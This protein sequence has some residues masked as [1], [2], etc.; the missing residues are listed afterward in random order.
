MGG[1]LLRSLYTLS[2]LLCTAGQLR[3]SLVKVVT[4][5]RGGYTRGFTLFVRWYKNVQAGNNPVHAYLVYSFTPSLAHV[6]PRVRTRDPHFRRPR[7]GGGCSHSADSR[8]GAKCGIRRFHGVQVPSVEGREVGKSVGGGVGEESGRGRRCFP[9][10]E[11]QSEPESAR[12]SR[13][14]PQEA[15]WP[16]G[17]QGVERWRKEPVRGLARQAQR[18]PVESDK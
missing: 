8:K 2:M 7:P 1:S 3:R 4:P 16:V 6:L 11:A 10:K 18:A 13:G 17:G 14:V 15:G 12:L 9:N 5:F